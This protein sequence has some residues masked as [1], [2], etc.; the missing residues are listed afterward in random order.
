[1]VAACLQDRD[2]ATGEPAATWR[3]TLLYDADGDVEDVW[4]EDGDDSMVFQM[5]KG[6][7][8]PTAPPLSV[9]KR[10]RRTLRRASARSAARSRVADGRG[11]GTSSGGGGDEAAAAGA[12]DGNDGVRAKRPRGPPPGYSPPRCWDTFF[13]SHNLRQRPHLP[14][15]WPVPWGKEGGFDA[16]AAEHPAVAFTSG[17]VS[18]PRDACDPCC[19]FVPP[20]H[21]TPND[22]LLL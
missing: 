13:R 20:H 5:H 6:Q 12:G 17:V 15:S 21:P 16:D 8:E 7:L 1:M 9:T 18:L 3:H 11:G 4:F 22:A 2:K 19:M 14:P 10:C